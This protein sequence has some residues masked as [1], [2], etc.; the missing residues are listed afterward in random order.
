MKLKKWKSFLH[1]SAPRS[2][3]AKFRLVVLAK[4]VVLAMRHRAVEVKELLLH[5]KLDLK[6]RFLFLMTILHSNPTENT[7]CTD[8]STLGST[9]VMLE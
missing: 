5:M 9:S 3:L 8:R 2:Q 1:P 7:S 4:W 6:N